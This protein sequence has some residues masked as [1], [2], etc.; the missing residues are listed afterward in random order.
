MRLFFAGDHAAPQ[1]DFARF[2]DNFLHNFRSGFKAI[3]CYNNRSGI[4]IHCLIDGSH[5]PV[6][7]QFFDEVD[8]TLFNLLSQITDDDAGRQF[9]FVSIVTHRATSITQTSNEQLQEM[10]LTHPLVVSPV[11]DST[12][13]IWLLTSPTRSASASMG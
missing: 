9:N 11:S 1:R 2:D 12:D 3:L 10:Q 4:K 8:G 13:H 6:G 5:H 7:H